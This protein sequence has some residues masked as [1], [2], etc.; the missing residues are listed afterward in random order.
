MSLGKRHFSARPDDETWQLAA[1]LKLRVAAAKGLDRISD[2]DL[3]RLALLS[4]DQH[5][6]PA[7]ERPTQ[8]RKNHTAPRRHATA[9]A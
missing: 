7:E 9:S 3:L 8:G 6:F 2:T 4:L 5:E 1:R